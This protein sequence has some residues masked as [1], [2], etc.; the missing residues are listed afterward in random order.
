MTPFRFA[1]VA[2]LASLSEFHGYFFYYLICHTGCGKDY[3]VKREHG[4]GMVYQEL[5]SRE[6]HKPFA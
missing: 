1:F 2:T 5:A 3:G 6:P 4:S